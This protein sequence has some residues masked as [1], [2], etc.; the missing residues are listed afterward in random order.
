MNNPSVQDFKDYFVRDF[1]Y[2]TDPAT[3]ILDSDI[4]KAYQ[5]TNMTIYTGFCV[6]QSSW[7]V[8][9]LLLSA[10]YLVTNIRSS[11]QGLNGSGA[12]LAQSKSVGSV[13][14]SYALPQT[15][16]EDPAFAQYATTAYGMEYLNLV[17][18]YLRGA[19]FTV[20]DGNEIPRS[21]VIPPQWR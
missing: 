18:P 11:S 8:V 1:P 10:H 19:M 21:A 14:T 12:L 17:M 13:S 16:S 2:G 15:L 6:V 7:N 9:Y 3:S 4:A 20:G 5:L